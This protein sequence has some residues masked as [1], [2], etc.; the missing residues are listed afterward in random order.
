M[1]AFPRTRRD[2]LREIDPALAEARAAGLSI[3]ELER[4]RR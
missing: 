1:T 4:L 2:M 3:A